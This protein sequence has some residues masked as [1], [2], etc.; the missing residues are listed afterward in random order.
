L[1]L[2]TDKYAL[3]SGSSICEKV[4]LFVI[5]TN[6]CRFFLFVYELILMDPR[7]FCKLLQADKYAVFSGSSICEK[8]VLFVI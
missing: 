8:V 4:V 1:L 3:F 2:Q 5:D 7:H 6:F